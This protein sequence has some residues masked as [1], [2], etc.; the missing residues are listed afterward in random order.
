MIRA[1]LSR[2][3]PGRAALVIALAGCAPRAYRVDAAHPAHPSAPTRRLAGPPAAPRPGVA[4]APSPP[5]TTD[6]HRH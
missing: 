5:A 6:P 1:R 3:L 2:A 4:D